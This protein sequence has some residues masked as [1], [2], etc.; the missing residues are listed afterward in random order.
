MPVEAPEGTEAVNIPSL[1]VKSTST[2]GFPRESMICRPCGEVASPG[3]YVRVWGGWGG[4][5]LGVVRDA[6]WVDVE[7]ERA[8]RWSI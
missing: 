5:G 8:I 3:A 1:V 4:G 6:G 2:V 7:S